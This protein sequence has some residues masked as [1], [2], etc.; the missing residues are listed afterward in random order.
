MAAC[1]RAITFRL[2]I[3]KEIGSKFVK[4]IENVVAYVF[5]I[6]IIYARRDLLS[7]MLSQRD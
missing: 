5:C 4:S 1:P 6:A 2:I 7:Y 3:T